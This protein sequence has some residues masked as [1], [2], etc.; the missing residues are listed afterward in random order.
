MSNMGILVGNE[1]PTNNFST[2]QVLSLRYDNVSIETLTIKE[3]SIKII[4][5]DKDPTVVKII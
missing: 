4:T 2:I 1:I 3:S 5:V